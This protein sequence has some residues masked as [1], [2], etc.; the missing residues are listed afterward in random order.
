MTDLARAYGRRIAALLWLLVAIWAVGLVLAPLATMIGHSAWTVETRSMEAGL[1][2]DRLYDDLA[3]LRWD[4]ERTTDPEKR[5]D[6][7][8]RIRMLSDRARLLERRD[9][10]PNVVY[11]LDN[12]ARLS[13]L[14]A[15]VLLRSLGWALLATAL[16]LVVCYPV[17]WAV[18]R[19]PTRTRA[20]V[21]VTGLL[22]PFALAEL[23]R[24]QAWA[25]ILDPRG[26]VAAT[27]A[28][29]G[30]FDPAT[31]GGAPLFGH[32]GSVFVA[33]VY[34]HVLFMVL[35]ILATLQT[36]DPHQ[37]EAARDLGASTLR[38]HLRVVLP[39]ARP[40]LAVGSILTFMLAAGSYA[41]PQI[42][43][44]GQGGDWFAQLVWRRF[45]EAA[46]WNVGA[47]YGTTLLVACLVVVFA[48][49]RLFRVRFGDLARRGGRHA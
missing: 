9:A 4:W 19:A 20:A 5:V 12:Y 44:R 7:D 6:L 14:H 30:L 8:R 48:L 21:L 3:A 35:P 1:A 31:A 26:L 46:D 49:A 23:L 32:Q 13:S 41:V 36:L 43:T 16:S 15:R 34:T 11:G 10:E 17:A 2:I 29:L 37:V 27:L 18:A 45:F 38:L 39:H 42:M 40:G 28:G 25:M 22:V 24:I 33:M 47:A